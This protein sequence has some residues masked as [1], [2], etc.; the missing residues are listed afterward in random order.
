MYDNVFSFP[1]QEVTLKYVFLSKLVK[2]R[3]MKNGQKAI[4]QHGKR[5]QIVALSS[6][7]F[8]VHQMEKKLKISKTAVRNAIMKY[9]SEGIFIDKNGL[10]DQG[11]PAAEKTSL[12]VRWLL[13]LQ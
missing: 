7:K 9:Q 10:A 5:T 8:S 13:A 3:G 12:C 4:F 1:A 2:V 11:F 6:L